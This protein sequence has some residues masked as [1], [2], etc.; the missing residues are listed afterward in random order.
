MRYDFFKTDG[1]RKEAGFA[2]TA[3][4]CV[5]RAVAIASGRRYR[6]VWNHLAEINA[7]H[8][9]HR[10]ADHGVL[11]DTVEFEEYMT[12]LGFIKNPVMA[13]VTVDDLAITS[14]C[15]VVIDF[16]S[17]SVA[18]VYGTFYDVNVKLIPRRKRYVRQYWSLREDW[19]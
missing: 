5:S 10:S 3:R 14:K 15:V 11:T 9:K 4:D 12:S 16:A 18:M 6:E 8:G 17:H 13:K 2:G 7:R 19:R 1:G